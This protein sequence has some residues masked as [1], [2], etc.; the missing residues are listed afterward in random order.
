MADV[1]TAEE[2]R[3]EEENLQSP[4]ADPDPGDPGHPS[5]VSDP[6]PPDVLEP[7]GDGGGGEGASS[8]SQSSEQP[9]P[10]QTGTGGEDS[11]GGRQTPGDGGKASSPSEVLEVL[12]KGEDPNG[13]EDIPPGALAAFKTA[14]AG[15]KENL[16]PGSSP[17]T[18]EVLRGTLRRIVGLDRRVEFSAESVQHIMGLARDGEPVNLELEQELLDE[19]KAVGIDLEAVKL[20]YESLLEEDRRQLTTFQVQRAFLSALERVEEVAAQV[21]ERLGL[22]I[23]LFE[24]QGK[25]QLKLVSALRVLFDSEEERAKRMVAGVRERLEAE[26]AALEAFLVQLNEERESLREVLEENPRHLAQGAKKQLD[27][28]VVALQK[29]IK[30]LHAD[31]KSSQTAARDIGEKVEVAGKVLESVKDEGSRVMTELER[32]AREGLAVRRL[33]LLGGVIGS[34]VGGFFAFVVLLLLWAV[35]G[36]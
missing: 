24:A 11:S 20:T 1:G 32:V 9:A 29:G 3:V 6:V 16:A 5:L 31:L 18:L 14:K 25:D 4:P 2:R 12:N 17:E 21:S 8:L 26:R 35:T 15:Q 28:Q 36:G 33:A 19:F 22:R 23:E 30:D 13:D 10:V 27:D 34:A 7:P